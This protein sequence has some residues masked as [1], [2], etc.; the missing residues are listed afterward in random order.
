MDWFA[1]E[2]FPN[3]LNRVLLGK[4]LDRQDERLQAKFLVAHLLQLQSAG[5]S[6]RLEERC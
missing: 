5:A 2:A 3:R 6:H 4:R 1:F